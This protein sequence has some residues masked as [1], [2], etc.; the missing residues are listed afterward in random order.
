MC[1][2]FGSGNPKGI[3]IA[4][5]NQKPLLVVDRYLVSKGKRPIISPSE[6]DPKV[7]IDEFI[8]L[9]GISETNPEHIN[10]NHFERWTGNAALEKLQDYSSQ[11]VD[12]VFTGINYVLP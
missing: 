7:A 9:A 12:S 8:R 4:E 2:G 1:S 5:Y 10:T 3:A 11:F 6:T